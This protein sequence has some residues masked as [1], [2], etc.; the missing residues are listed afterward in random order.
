MDA[1]TRQI[2]LEEFA[3]QCRE[4]G[5]PC[6]VQ[7]RVILEAVLGRDDHPTADQVFQGVSERNRGIS[8]ATVHRTLDTLVRMS[9]ITKACHPGKA[10]R[11]DGRIE[12]HHHLVCMRCDK[13]IDIQDEHLDSLRI[14]DT[15][16]FGFE[17]VD[18][19]VQLRGLCKE[20]R[21]EG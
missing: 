8:R 14:P 19:R 16:A 4:R 17:A 5:V 11:Y 9:V 6:T 20:C 7:R 12:I 15:S 2:R 21:Q 1:R 10:T 18:F 13:I 3:R